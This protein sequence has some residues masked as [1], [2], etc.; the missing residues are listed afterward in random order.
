MQWKDDAARLWLPRACGTVALNGV[1]AQSA[2]VF[3][4]LRM[5]GNYV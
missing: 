1:G 5:L 4:E 3:G 2:C